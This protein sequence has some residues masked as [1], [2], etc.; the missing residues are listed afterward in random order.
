MEHP[1]PYISLSC[2]HTHTPRKHGGNKT[3]VAT[4]LWQ[5]CWKYTAIKSSNTPKVDQLSHLSKY[6]RAYQNI[7]FM[8]S[9][10]HAKDWMGDSASSTIQS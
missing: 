1:I 8:T 5:H 7:T 4:D 3:E 9:E 10:L 6:M 2:T